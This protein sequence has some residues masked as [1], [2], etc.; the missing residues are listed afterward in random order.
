MMRLLIDAGNSR[1]KWALARGEKLLA[2]EQLPVAQSAQLN[3]HFA[4]RAYDNVRQVWV[5]NVAGTKVEHRV[6]D[7]CAVRHWSPRFIV[8][9]A[10]QCGVRNGY[11]QAAQLGCDRWA[12]L[13]AAWHQ[14]GAACLV[15]NSGTATTLDALSDAG[16]FVGGLILPGLE[17]MQRSLTMSTAQLQGV[18]G[19]YASFPRNTND[20]L[21]SGAIQATCGA[22][23][24]QYALLGKPA[25]AVLLGG[26]AAL[27]LQSHLGLPVVMMDNPVLQGL[28]LIARE[29]SE[30]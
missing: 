18:G 15:V 12:A 10:A 2:V 16:E 3:L 6:R 14:L 11:E 22:I 9:E 13:L 24:R 29:A 1:I 25:A 23:Q 17:L 5:S 30:A 28:L 27:A 26:G 20:A 21:T 7:A 4:E 19:N 8:A